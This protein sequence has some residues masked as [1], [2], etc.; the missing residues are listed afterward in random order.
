M[1]R[2]KSTKNTM[3][4]SEIDKANEAYFY[5][6]KYQPPDPTLEQALAALAGL[7]M[8][9]LDDEAKVADSLMNDDMIYDDEP[10][11]PT[12]T[13]WDDLPLC[14]YKDLR[15]LRAYLEAAAP[16][17]A[18]TSAVAESGVSNLAGGGGA[19]ARA[20]VAEASKKETKR[21]GK[22]KAHGL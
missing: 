5:K 10:N 15:V 2:T 9:W 17:S 20:F 4:L 14:N 1:T 6:D 3:S 7:E 16:A 19:R 13:V 11:D 21:L 22:R 8:N 18:G 12:K